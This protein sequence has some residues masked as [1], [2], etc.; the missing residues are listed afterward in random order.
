MRQN[1]RFVVH[2]NL[3]MPIH[4]DGEMFAYPA[5][6]VHTVTITTLPAALRIVV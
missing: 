3:P 1:R 6:N 4:I 2:S 5:D